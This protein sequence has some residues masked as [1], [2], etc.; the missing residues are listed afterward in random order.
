MKQSV[1]FIMLTFAICLTVGMLTI[2]IFAATNAS[3]RTQT[4]ITWQAMGIEMDMYGKV[5]GNKATDNITNTFTDSLKVDDLAEESSWSIGHIH[6]NITEDSSIRYCEP[7]IFRFG[8]TNTS[9]DN[10]DIY[11]CISDAPT[12][13]TNVNYEYQLAYGTL[14]SSETWES[15]FFA[16][17]YSGNM[18]SSI[19]SSDYKIVD[20]NSTTNYI[21][22]GSTAVFEIR[23]TVDD[24]TENISATALKMTIQFRSHVIT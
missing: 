12:T 3:V 21:E 16:S 2:G 8:I 23:L 5:T 22:P 10:V 19:I 13:V 17:D 15:D 7:I 14:S 20:K 18:Q 6:F 24:I 4:V 1:K 11:Y 9:Q